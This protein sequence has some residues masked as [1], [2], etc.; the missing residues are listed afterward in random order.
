MINN[1]TSNQVRNVNKLKN[2]DIFFIYK[3]KKKKN[4]DY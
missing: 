2:I 3:K 1:G 4:E